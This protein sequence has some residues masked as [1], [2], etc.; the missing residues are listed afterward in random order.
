VNAVRPESRTNFA[1]GDWKKDMHRRTQGP[2]TQTMRDSPH[3]A[4]HLRVMRPRQISMYRDR[5]SLVPIS[6]VLSQCARTSHYPPG[7]PAAADA[8]SSRSIAAPT[9]VG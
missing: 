5:L 2:D 9:H 7:A 1:E 4:A 8:T 3:R 6:K